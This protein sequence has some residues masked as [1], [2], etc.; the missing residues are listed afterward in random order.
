MCVACRGALSG[1]S[2][3]MPV[4]EREVAMGGRILAYLRAV[5]GDDV[6][7]VPGSEMRSALGVRYLS[8][9]FYVDSN[10]LVAEV[11]PEAN[12]DLFFPTHQMEADFKAICFSPGNVALDVLALSQDGYTISFVRPVCF[13]PPSTSSLPANI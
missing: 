13:R 1:F 5:R 7:V 2:S 6:K 3:D 11:S 9:L 8:H 10:A 12:Y 4:S